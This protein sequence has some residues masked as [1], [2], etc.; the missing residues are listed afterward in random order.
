MKLY[1]HD[2]IG[3]VE[4]ISSTQDGDL[5][6]VNAARCS[7]DKQHEDFDEKKRYSTHQLSGEREACPSLSPSTTHCED[8]STYLH[9]AADR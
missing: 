6:V 9:I 3:F 2:E 4:D 1:I 7:L 8:V 5:L